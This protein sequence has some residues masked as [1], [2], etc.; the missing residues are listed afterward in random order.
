LKSGLKIGTPVTRALENVHTNFGFYVFF[1]FELK[2]RMGHADRRT[3]K[4]RNAAS[5][6]IAL[7]YTSALG[8]LSWDV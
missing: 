2:A 6:S 1:A 4:T 7:D 8:G 5:I 3:G